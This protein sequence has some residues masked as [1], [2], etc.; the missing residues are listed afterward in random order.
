MNKAVV[1]IL[2]T[3][4]VLVLLYLGVVIIASVTQLAD[5]ADRIYLGSG[6]AVFWGFLTAL[7]LLLVTPLVL[8]YRLPKP[9]IPPAEPTDPGFEEYLSELRHHLKRNPRLAGMALNSREDIEE[10]MAKLSGEADEVIR[11]TASTVFVS[12][13]VMQNGRLDGLIVL[14]TQI[15]MVWRIASI[16][17]QR[18]T[19]RQ[20]LYL[21]S[22]V[23]AATLIADSIQEIEFSELATP[24]VTAIIPSLKGAIPGMQGVA[25]LLVNSIASGAANA[26]L[27]LRVGII[28]RRYCESLTTPKRHDVRQ[29]ATASALL[30][31]GRITKENGAR[32]VQNSWGAVRDAVGGAIDSAVE[33][34]KNATDKVVDATVS[35]ARTVGDA[36]ASTTRSVMNTAGK[37]ASKREPT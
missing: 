11:D 8:F 33:G 26:F 2:T 13:A 24:L 1:R 19:P 15:R 27:T 14:A 10:A 23:G 30:L 32:V 6:Q 18:P 9:L 36:I 12:T 29:A 31:V 28:A 17:Y 22:N 37:V 7:A 20:V 34:A 4:G 21:Y 16:Y 3:I 25:S 5:A 35:S